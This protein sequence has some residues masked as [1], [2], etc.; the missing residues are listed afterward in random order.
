MKPRAAFL[1]LT[2]LGTTLDAQIPSIS[3]G[4]DLCS[5]FALGNPIAPV[6][7][8]ELQ[9]RGLGMHVLVYDDE[10]RAVVGQKGELVCAAPFPSMP[11][12]FWR[13]PDGAAYSQAY[14]EKSFHS[15]AALMSMA[16][17][18]GRVC[19]AG[20]AGA[21]S[22]C[23]PGHILSPGGCLP[24]QSRIRRASVSRSSTIAS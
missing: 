1:A 3:G 24:R 15:S 23:G 22:A 10:G 6:Y 20:C 9:T 18:P 4:T 11:L 19:P 13:D 17:S 5:C 8:G 2:W 7:R 16:C 12:G 21:P 14:F